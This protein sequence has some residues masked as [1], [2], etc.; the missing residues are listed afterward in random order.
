MIKKTIQDAINRQLNSE[1]YSAYLYL[2]M[3]SYFDSVNQPGFSHWM[4]IQAQEEVAHGM[5][6]YDYLIQQKNRV[7]MS[8]IETPQLEWVSPI[9]AFEH[10]LSHEKA[11]TSLINNLVKLATDEKDDVTYE[12]LKWFVKEQVEEEMSAGHALKKVK[13]AGTDKNK[14]SIVDSSLGKRVFKP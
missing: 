5:R 1:L 8:D 7:L 9:A 2:S 13:E 4:K 3:A 6:F 12:F 11:V 14:I 10:V